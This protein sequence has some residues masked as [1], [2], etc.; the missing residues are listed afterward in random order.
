[1]KIISKILCCIL[2]IVLVGGV[3]AGGRCETTSSFNCGATFPQNGNTCGGK[4]CCCDG[5]KGTGM[6]VNTCTGGDGFKNIGC[7]SCWGNSACRTTTNMNIGSNSCLGNDAC[8]ASSDST[9]SNDSCHGNDACSHSSD[10]TFSK[11]SCHGK[12]A[13]R[14]TS[15][16]TFLNDSCHGESSC[17][18]QKNMKIGSNSCKGEYACFY[19]KDSTISNDSCNGE[20][21]CQRLNKVTIGNGSCNA[22]NVCI[23]GQFC[24]ANSIVPDNACNDLGGVD[25]TWNG[26]FFLCNYCWSID[27][28]VELGFV[29]TD[30]TAGRSLASCDDNHDGTSIMKEVSDIVLRFHALRRLKNTFKKM[31]SGLDGEQTLTITVDISTRGMNK[32][33]MPLNQFLKTKLE[34]KRAESPSCFTLQSIVVVNRDDP[35]S[36]PS[37]KKKKSKSNKKQT[38][39]M[40][41]K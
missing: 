21:A 35:A 16:S 38:A 34:E 13:C 25:T 40:H 15:D 6:Q 31:S 2:A 14:D 17:Q 32:D 9:F 22:K 11:D 36:L 27:T 23:G 5:K 20:T 3:D 18:F 19:A 41:K 30:D 39:S 33:E 24:F 28:Q 10:S 26:Y 8:R 12:D 29:T 37:W 1:M 4:G 7:E